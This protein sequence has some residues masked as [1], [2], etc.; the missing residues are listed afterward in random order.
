VLFGTQNTAPYCQKYIPMQ[1]A[2][3]EILPTGLCGIVQ[4]VPF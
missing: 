2:F 4:K 3:S 1:T